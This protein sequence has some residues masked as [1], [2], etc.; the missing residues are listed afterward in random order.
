MKRKIPVKKTIALCTAVF[1]IFFY[2]VPGC[3]SV[4]KKNTTGSSAERTT[5]NITFTD[6]LGNNITLPGEAHRIIV[7][8][9]GPLEILIAIGAGDRIVGTSDWAVNNPLFKDQMP[10]A[11]SIGQYRTPDV[12]KIISLKPDLVI[13]YT[14]AKPKNLDQL[15]ANNL[16]II[17]LDGYRLDRVT[18]DIKI[19]G[20]I[21]GEQRNASRYSQV[22]DHYLSIVQSRLSDVPTEQQPSVYAEE[23]LDYY[24]DGRESTAGDMLNFLHVNNIAGNSIAST[25]IV[26]PEWVIAQN[27][28]IIIKQGLQGTNLTKIFEGVIARQGF[29]KISA[30]KNKKVYIY[31]S[32]V[33]STPHGYIGLLYFAKVIYPDRFSDIDLQEVLH[34]YSHDF[35]PGSDTIDT[36]YPSLASKSGPS[37]NTTNLG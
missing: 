1:L 13:C 4:E 11:Q 37:V 6:G 3:T 36:F 30:I 5:G 20:E 19:M 21:T 22:I 34:E 8:S 32:S 10:N 25:T 31:D 7:Q 26:S 14:S 17:Y 23:L 27:P 35:L 24:I 33:G 9:N 18:T 15:I 29:S 28:D 2:T 12:E 16:T